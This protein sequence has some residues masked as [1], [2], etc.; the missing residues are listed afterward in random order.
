M[1][2]SLK[3]LLILTVTLKTTIKYNIHSLNFL[4]ICVDISE[5]LMH[6]N[7]S[8]KTRAYE[9]DFK[10]QSNQAHLTKTRGI[11]TFFGHLTSAAHLTNSKY[12]PVLWNLKPTTPGGTFLLALFREIWFKNRIK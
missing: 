1:L 10:K 12:S 5:N 8:C 7:S 9:T 4:Q 11:Y 6:K 3:Q 2:V